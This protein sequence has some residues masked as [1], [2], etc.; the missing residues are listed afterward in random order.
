MAGTIVFLMTQHSLLMVSI[1]LYVILQFI[2][3]FWSFL[4]VVL[5]VYVW[6]NLNNGRLHRMNQCK[7]MFFLMTC[8][9]VL[10]ITDLIDLLSKQ[11][12]HLIFYHFS[13]NIF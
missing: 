13:A 10:L 12:M 4:V 9:L 2:I 6:R 1:D 3:E 7:H 8:H 11:F 5:F